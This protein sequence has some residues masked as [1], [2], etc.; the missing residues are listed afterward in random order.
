LTRQDQLT[1]A[2]II[3]RDALRVQLMR[4]EDRIDVVGDPDPRLIDDAHRHFV[5][6]DLDGAAEAVT[7][8]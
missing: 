4:R 5:Q 3:D 8:V 6:A 2:V 1:P 7:P